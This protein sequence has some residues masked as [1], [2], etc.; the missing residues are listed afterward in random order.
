MALLTDRELEVF[1]LLGQGYAPRHIAEKLCRSTSTVE[2]HREQIKEKLN[3]ESSP[4]LIRYAIQWCRDQAA[5][6]A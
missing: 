3:L 2:A 4:V 1:L 6:E 5:G